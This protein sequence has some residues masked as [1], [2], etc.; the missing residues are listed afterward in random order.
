MSFFVSNTNTV[1]VQQQIYNSVFNSSIQ[2][3]VNVCS[4][5]QDDNLVF[6]D[7][8][9]GNITLNQTCQVVGNSCMLKTLVDTNIDNVLESL[10]K[11]KIFSETDL[12]ALN[13]GSNSSNTVNADQMIR[14]IISQTVASTCKEGSDQTKEV[15]LTF[16]S[17]TAGDISI[18]QDSNI[19]SNTCTLNNA[20]KTVLANKEVSKT[21]QGITNIGILGII[22]AIILFVVIGIVIVV[23]VHGKTLMTQ[24]NS[25]KNLVKEQEKYQ[26]EQKDNYNEELEKEE[27]LYNQKVKTSYAKPQSKPLVKLDNNLPPVTRNIR[28]DLSNN[29]RDNI[30]KQANNV[31][32]SL[33]DRLSPVRSPVRSPFRT[34]SF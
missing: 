20:I 24:S 32:K 4:Q 34:T 25:Q 13:F 7:S 16:I 5:E 18:G 31:Y 11:Q 15:N 6:V 3:C 1:N 22:A 29:I 30:K 19:S 21:D 23:I 14:N 27:Q 17:S 28:N 10:A 2:N 12:S 8:K 26:Q 9:V 33:N